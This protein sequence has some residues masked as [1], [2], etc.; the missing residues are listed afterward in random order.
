MSGPALRPVG[1][2]AVG[3]AS[4]ATV[5]PIVGVG[6][7]FAPTDAVAYARAGASLV[8]IGTASFAAP[9]AAEKV[10][11]GLSSWGRPSDRWDDLR[12]PPE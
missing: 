7:V 5:L 8:E 6:G 3:I 2:R 4:A 1:L 10:V 12:A 9:R 11:R